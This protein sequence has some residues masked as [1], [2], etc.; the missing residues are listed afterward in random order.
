MLSSSTSN[1]S[2]LAVAA[3]SV[4][5]IIRDTGVR[6]PGAATA[7]V[8]ASAVPAAGATAGY[9]AGGLPGLPA[10]PGR[11]VPRPTG[12]PEN[13][14]VL[15]WA[16]FKA[17]VTYTFDDT[18]S[19]QIQHYAELQALGVRM[20]FYLIT[21]KTPEFNDPIWARAVRDGH[22]IGSHSNSHRH[23]GTTADMEAS[24]VAI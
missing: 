8:G 12:A 11:G 21:G 14:T 10:P 17:A 24:D 3:M 18:N 7:D 16:G 23:T 6:A 9:N 5:C 22:E 20:T 4:G 2:M 13:L 15:D 1:L 19:S